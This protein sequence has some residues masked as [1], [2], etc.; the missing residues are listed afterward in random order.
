M[1]VTTLMSM[2]GLAILACASALAAP[3]AYAQEPVPTPAQ[4]EHTVRRGDTLWDLARSYLADPFRWPMIYEA[5]RRIVENPHRIFPA[6]KLII[7]GVTEEV[8]TAVVV[9]AVT[10]SGPNRSRF[11]VATAPN[12]A[13]PTLISTEQQRNAFIRPMEYIAAPWIAD[14]AQLML[15]GQVLNSVDP[16]NAEDKLAQTFH[17]RDELY[18]SSLGGSAA[19]AHGQA[20][21]RL[22]VIRMSRTLKP[23]GWLIEPMGIIRIDSVGSTASRAMVIQQFA[24]LKVGDLT[25]PLPSV[26]T[27]PTV[28]PIDISGGA[29]GRIIDFMV[30]QPLYGTTDIGFVDLGSSKGI[31][32]GDEL[33]AFIPERRPD[34]KKPDVLPEEIVARMRVIKLTDATA[35]VRITRV[36]ESGL[37]HQLPVRHS[38]QAQ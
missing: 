37:S 15:N 24:D 23:Y 6:E 3:A 31:N 18:L 20:G 32:I 28:E 12:T 14:S 13:A 33:V 1:R 19:S 38:K 35:T 25:I 36:H 10:P 16:R 11:Y 2:R 27:L 21:N 9:A 34:K 4:K 5:N 22:L 7:P 8:D 26:P 29:T 17:P 30:R